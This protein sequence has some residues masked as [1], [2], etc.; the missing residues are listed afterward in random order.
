MPA[1][2]PPP[3]Q[4]IRR[5][6]AEESAVTAFMRENLLVAALTCIFLGLFVAPSLA[7]PICR[8]S[9]VDKQCQVADCSVCAGRS[10]TNCAGS[11]PAWS[12][13]SIN[14]AYSEAVGAVVASGGWKN[15]QF[16]CGELQWAKNGAPC[17]WNGTQ[18]VCPE[19]PNPGN[20]DLWEGDE[21]IFCDN[22]KASGC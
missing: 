13:C 1:Y 11:G 21:S 16:S 15:T 10:S 19:A 7:G 9:K 6:S 20:D 12:R 3:D 22:F 17:I 4:L 18:C 14:F 2:P 5:D 8:A